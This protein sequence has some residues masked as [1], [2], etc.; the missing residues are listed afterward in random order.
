MQPEQPDPDS[1]IGHGQLFHPGFALQNQETQNFYGF[2]KKK[3]RPM[4][5]AIKAALEN[6]RMVS[7]K[8]LLPQAWAVNPLVPMLRNPRLQYMKL[9][10]RDPR[11]MAPI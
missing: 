7:G 5:M 4:T 3:H 6:T 10:I 8:S 2:L 1:E 11:A 9:K